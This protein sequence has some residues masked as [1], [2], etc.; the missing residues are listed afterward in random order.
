M[1]KTYTNGAILTINR[2]GGVLEEIVN[3]AH[4]RNGVI[5]GAVFAASVQATRKAGRGEIVAQRPNVLPVPLRTQRM[6]IAG[7][8]GDRA[9]AFPGSLGSLEADALE[10]ELVEF[11]DSHQ[12]VVAKIRTDRSERTAEG[13]ARALRME[14]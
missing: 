5:P 2:P 1:D 6:E 14:D 12:N 9:G 8:L 13:V 4:A 11:D 10:K 7:K 3:T